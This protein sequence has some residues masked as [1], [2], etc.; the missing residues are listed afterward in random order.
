M[1]PHTCSED[2]LVEQ[3]AIGLFA[4]LGWQTVSTLKET[5]GPDGTLGRESG[6]KVVLLERIQGSSTGL[7]CPAD[8]SWNAPCVGAEA[9]AAS[10]RP[11]RWTTRQPL[12]MHRNGVVAAAWRRGPVPA[13]RFISSRRKPCGSL[14]G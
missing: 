7:P 10:P 2:Q 1:S 3:P 12:P 8:A 14:S 5:F 13:R 4:D 9:T 11:A 6:G